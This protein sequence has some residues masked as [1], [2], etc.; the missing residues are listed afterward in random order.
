[1]PDQYGE[2]ESKAEE[3]EA[4]RK[5]KMRRA[6]WLKDQAKLWETHPEEMARKHMFDDR[7]VEVLGQVEVNRLR[8]EVS[9][10]VKA[11]QAEDDYWN[12]VTV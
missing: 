12:S 6:V 2:Y 10:R 11:E 5:R 1:M 9:E 8:Q 7:A 4:D 3:R